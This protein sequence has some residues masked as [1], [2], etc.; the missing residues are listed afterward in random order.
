[1]RTTREKGN[2][3][4]KSGEERRDLYN[5]LKLE[6]SV[7]LYYSSLLSPLSSVCVISSC[8]FESS[9]PGDGAGGG[10]QNSAAEAGQAGQ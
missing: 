3:A 6:K 5:C 2:L 10:D 4:V 1:M 8:L 9:H 7:K